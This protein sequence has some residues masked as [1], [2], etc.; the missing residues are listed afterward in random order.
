MPFSSAR[1]DRMA[2]SCCSTPGAS[3]ATL[4]LG[5]ARLALTDYAGARES[6]EA[7]VLAHPTV[8]H[9]HM[10]FRARAIAGLSYIEAHEGNEPGAI[11]LR[12]ELRRMQHFSNIALAL[13]YTGAGNHGRATAALDRAFEERDPLCPFVKSDPLFTSYHRELRDAG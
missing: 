10:K 6:F 5:F 1:N 11:S 8:L 3:F 13:A 2:N 4:L 12:E 7:L 9:Q